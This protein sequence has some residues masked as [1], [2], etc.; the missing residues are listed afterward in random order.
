MTGHATVADPVPTQSAN[1]PQHRSRSSPNGAWPQ[2]FD[3]LPLALVISAVVTACGSCV[4]LLA[5]SI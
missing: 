2:I 4:L 1:A 5:T 3:I